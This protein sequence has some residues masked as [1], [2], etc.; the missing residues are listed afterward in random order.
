[1]SQI[2]RRSTIV[3]DW[4]PR[5]TAWE[6]ELKHLRAFVNEYKHCAV[7]TKYRS[8]DGYSLGQWV[9]G[10]RQKRSSLSVERKAQLDA[11]GFIWNARTT[12]VGKAVA[13]D[14]TDNTLTNSSET[15]FTPPK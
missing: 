1:V 9:N 4:S 12:G 10:L 15:I 2:A 3:S 7:P 5:D 13:I 11:L 8:P 6:E 14:S